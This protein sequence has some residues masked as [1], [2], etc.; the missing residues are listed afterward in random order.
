MQALEG[1]ELLEDMLQAR[2]KGEE[3]DRKE[4]GVPEGV[5]LQISVT[6]ELAVTT[7][8]SF[9]VWDYFFWW[10]KPHKGTT[11][12]RSLDLSASFTWGNAK[13]LPTMPFACGIIQ[14]MVFSIA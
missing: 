1:Q 14:F 12:F 9:K 7:G 6:K 2:R 5:C 3:S 11:I 13:M 4:P 8:L 10:L